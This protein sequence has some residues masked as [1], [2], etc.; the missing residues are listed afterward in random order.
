M[1][2]DSGPHVGR[3]APPLSQFPDL[4]AT[5]AD[6]HLYSGHGTEHRT[7]MSADEELPTATTD[8]KADV[9]IWKRVNE[10]RPCDEILS[11]HHVARLTRHHRRVLSAMAALRRLPRKRG[12]DC[13]AVGGHAVSSTIN[14][15][16]PKDQQPK[17]SIVGMVPGCAIR[18]VDS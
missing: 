8:L 11:A 2:L 5:A 18:R 7:K 6:Q 14:S 13:R 12:F 9:S 3:F 17:G 16:E 4:S 10:A 15:L 1:N